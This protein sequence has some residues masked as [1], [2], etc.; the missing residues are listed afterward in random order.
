MVK[1]LRD[2]NAPKRPATAYFQWMKINRKSVVQSMP[3]GYSLKQLSTKMS[4]MW[5]A[6]P[7]EQKEEFNVKYQEEMKVWKKINAAY[8][9]TADYAEF[10]KEKQEFNLKKKAKT[11]KFHKDP[12]RPKAPRSAYF[13]F[14]ANKRA[15]VKTNFPN[16][17]NRETL[18]KLGETWSKLSDN[19]KRPYV[20]KA[21]QERSKWIE[22]VKDYEK[23]D[24][25][26][27]YLKQK[28]VF[29]E[30]R[31]V[32]KDKS[33]PKK[34][35]KQSPSVRR[36]TNTPK[37]KTSKGRSVKRQN[38]K[39]TKASGKKRMNKVS[40]KKTSRKKKAKKSREELHQ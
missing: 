39:A 5:A 17:N 25:Y 8:K 9:Q 15:D 36:V 23:T 19:E 22:D 14:L 31:K 13:I 20:T 32:V 34:A 12:N 3:V 6:L 37:K 27:E 38:T 1:R 16:L 33:N 18:S 4:E 2:A 26:K 28:K 29:N 11:G 21:I 10:L 35:S 40:R 30:S 7:E 24:K